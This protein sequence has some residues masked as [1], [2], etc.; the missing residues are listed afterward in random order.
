MKQ[1]I[2]SAHF[3]LRQLNLFLNNVSV[4]EYNFQLQVL[5]GSSI[6]MHV[7]HVIEFYQC[8]LNDRLSGQINYDARERNH[9]LETNIPFAQTSIALIQEELNRIPS[10]ASLT[11][12]TEQ[13]FETVLLPI[14][15]NFCRE[16]SY[17]IE[18]TIHHLAIIKIACISYFPAIQLDADFGVAYSTIKYRNHVHSHLPASAE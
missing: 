1:L 6:G 3:T 9:L 17:V 11:L 18:H 13:N 12:V 16:L 2:D 15:T 8:L 14:E 4:D 7:R 10:N 5:S